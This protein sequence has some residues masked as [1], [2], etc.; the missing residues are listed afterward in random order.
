MSID[1]SMR[2]NAGTTPPVCCRPDLDLVWQVITCKSRLS[3]HC[4]HLEI[5]DLANHPTH[6]DILVTENGG[7][8]FPIQHH[9]RS[10]HILLPITG[11]RKGGAMCICST[12]T[13]VPILNLL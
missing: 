10:K 9:S 11:N 8:Y 3:V 4:R 13:L 7:E 12:V 5:H 1:A 6:P 2:C